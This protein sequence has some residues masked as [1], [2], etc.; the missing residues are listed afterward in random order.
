MQKP[1]VREH[2]QHQVLMTGNVE[3]LKKPSYGP[4]TITLHETNLSFM[5]AFLNKKIKK[6]KKK[7]KTE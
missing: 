5:L 2:K 1:A 6:K 4:I 3:N 7:E